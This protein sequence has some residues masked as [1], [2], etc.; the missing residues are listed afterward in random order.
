MLGISQFPVL[1]NFGIAVALA[2][3]FALVTAFVYLPA[4]ALLAK[5]T[6]TYEIGRDS[7]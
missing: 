6:N 3:T 2:M 4:S 7:V 1:A 5:W